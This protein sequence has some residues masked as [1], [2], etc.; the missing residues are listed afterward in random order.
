M[1][2]RFVGFIASSCFLLVIKRNLTLR[3]YL[4]QALRRLAQNREA[5][6]KSRMRKKVRVKTLALDNFILKF[7]C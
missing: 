6:R 5:A 7:E 1:I 3:I 2:R 4:V